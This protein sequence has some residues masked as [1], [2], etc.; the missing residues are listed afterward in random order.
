MCTLLLNNSFEVKKYV[1]WPERKK[2]AI[3]LSNF[4]SKGNLAKKIICLLTK[5]TEKY[6]AWNGLFQLNPIITPT[7]HAT[8]TTVRFHINYD[9]DTIFY[10]NAARKLEGNKM[11]TKSILCNLVRVFLQCILCISVMNSLE[12]AL[13]KVSEEK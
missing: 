6:L 5:R 13:R 12:M 1:I 9:G 4:G 10:M 3:V 2:N 11:F 8:A 7:D